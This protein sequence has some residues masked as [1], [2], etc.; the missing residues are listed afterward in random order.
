MWVRRL[1]LL[2]RSCRGRVSFSSCAALW[3]RLVG[4]W[5]F[6]LGS[7]VFS[8]SYEAFS[9]VW[10]SL[11]SHCLVDRKATHCTICQDWSDTGAL[12]RQ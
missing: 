5:G 10:F 9:Q 3:I 2:L 7:R 12:G 11:F 4:E 8:L 1:G 6:P